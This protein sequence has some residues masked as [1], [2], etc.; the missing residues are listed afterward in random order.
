MPHKFPKAIGK[1]KLSRDKGSQSD[2]GREIVVLFADVVGCSEVSN[3][4]SI[5]DYEKF[6]NS[7]HEC[8]KRVCNYYKKHVYEPHEFNLFQVET[9]GDEGCLKIF[10][11]KSGEDLARDVDVA[12]SIA[13]DLKTLWL[14]SGHNRDRI[15]DGKLLPIELAI[16]IHMGKVWMTV[17]SDGTYKVE[18][19]AIN[20]AKRIE[21]ASRSG[22][23]THILVSESAHGQLYYHR[24]E[25]V[26][27]FTDAFTIPTKGIS[28]DIRVLEVKHHFLATDWQDVIEEEPWEISM[29]YPE[30]GQGDVLNI[31][32]RSYEINPTNLWLAEEYLMLTMMDAYRK[33]LEKN[34]EIGSK[35]LFAMGYDRALEIAQRI[36][37]SDLRDGTLLSDWGLILGELE[38]FEEEEEKYR[39]AICL[40]KSDPDFHW[41]LGLCLSYRINRDMEQGKFPLEVFY[42]QQGERVEEALEEYTT[43]LDLSPMNPW[44]AYIYA[45]ELSH[46]SPANK[47]LREPAINMLIRALSQKKEI[48]EW[49]E[50]EEYLEPII[51]DSRVKQCLR[52]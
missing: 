2:G 5:E 41:Y 36:T 21:S 31:A 11:A 43:A 17:N 50:K 25:R 35:N 42:K 45:C 9:R 33:C 23:F 48:R 44:I 4:S 14:F 39:E 3:H 16:G 30:L 34:K 46:W 26:Y 38:R 40:E 7:F 12:I 37:N 49:A 24:D 51:A 52:I 18:G 20:L 32:E 29:V 19:Y 28:Q 6:I 22:K 10:V 8:F 1:D 47:D 27:K 15:N 13:L